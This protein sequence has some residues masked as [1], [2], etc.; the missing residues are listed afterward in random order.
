MTFYPSLN[1][2][3]SLRQTL[4]GKGGVVTL[5]TQLETRTGTTAPRGVQVTIEA[6]TNTAIPVKVSSDA[7]NFMAFNRQKYPVPPGI[8]GVLTV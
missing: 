7:D 8:P 6:G 1:S 5:L 3:D 4:D 2:R